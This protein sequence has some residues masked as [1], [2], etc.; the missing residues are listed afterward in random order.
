MADSNVKEVHFGPTPPFDT[1]KPWQKT[2]AFGAPLGGILYFDKGEWRDPSGTPVPGS[3]VIGPPGPQGPQGPRGPRGFRGPQG[4]CGG[5]GAVGP[6]GPQGP[7]GPQGDP[8][9]AGP[10]GLTGP[11]GPAGPEGPVGPQGPAR[12]GLISLERAPLPDDGVEGD[13][14]IDIRFPA[15]L[16]GPKISGGWALIGTVGNLPAPVDLAG[17]GTLAENRSYYDTFASNRTFT[18]LPTVTGTA[19]SHI[20][21]YVEATAPV[22]LDFHTNTPTLEEVGVGTVAAAFSLPAGWHKLDFER[23]NGQWIV[24]R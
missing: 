8:G 12:F 15:T 13:L 18:A 4:T 3:P 19:Y 16:Y 17:S 7:P 5:D 1:C 21:L 11:A 6:A 9:P 23:I 22:D 10:T 24:T 14:A 2:T 20:C